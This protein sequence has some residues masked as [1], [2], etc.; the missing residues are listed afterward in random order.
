MLTVKG[1][2]GARGCFEMLGLLRATGLDSVLLTE[3]QRVDTDLLTGFI[4]LGREIR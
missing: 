1:L 2:G 3:M 4:V